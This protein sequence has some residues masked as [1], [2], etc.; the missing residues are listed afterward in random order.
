MDP[1]ISEAWM[2]LAR[3]YE[4]SGQSEAA[5][6]A[7]ARSEALAADSGSTDGRSVEPAER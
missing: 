1:P 7:R 4:Q 2:L 3:L 6:A 5:S